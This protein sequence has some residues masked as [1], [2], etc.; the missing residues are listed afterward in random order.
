MND[1]TKWDSTQTMLKL[2]GDL[3]YDMSYQFTNE[4]DFDDDQ[5]MFLRSLETPPQWLVMDREFTDK[6]VFL[7]YFENLGWQPE[8][9]GFSPKGPRPGG[10]EVDSNGN[11][12]STIWQVQH[13]I[14]PTISKKPLDDI[15][16]SELFASFGRDRNMRIYISGGFIAFYPDGYSN[17]VLLEFY[18]RPVEGT[19]KIMHGEVHYG[20]KAFEKFKEMRTFVPARGHP[21]S[22]NRWI[23]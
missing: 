18:D 15:A 11:P 14:A 8:R 23:I 4:V 1:M 5:K 6:S 3:G 10:G 2:F 7:D 17:M 12:I 13:L 16:N 21:D 20:E 9:K 22:I 19:T